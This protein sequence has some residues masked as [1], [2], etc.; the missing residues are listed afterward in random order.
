MKRYVVPAI[1]AAL[2]VGSF[3]VTNASAKSATPKAAS[4]ACPAAPDAALDAKYGVGAGALEQALACGEA[5]KLKAKGDPVIV[6][7]MNP[8]GDPAG[9]FPEYT[10]MAQAAVD[11]INTE[12]GGIGADY[13]TGTPGRPI[14]LEVCKMAINPADS[15]KCANELAAKKPLVV[16]STLNFFG[17][18][19]KILND[20][21]IPV[22]VGTPISPG[23]FT[24]PGVYAIGGG[25]GCLGVHTGLIEYLTNDVLK[26]KAN[27]KIAVPWAN[28]PPGVFCYH[29]LEKKPLNVLNGT[30]GK[31][32]SKAAGKMKGMTHIGV[33]I[34]PGS[35]D[36]T[37]DAQ[38]VLEFKPD[39]MVYSA[40]GADCWTFV[41]GLLK[42]GW[43]P[44]TPL[45]LSGAC[46]DLTTMRALGDKI[47][48][49][50][51]VGASSILD[52]DALIDPQ[53][54]R[55]AKIYGAKGKKYAK[56]KTSLEKG[57]GTQ[58]FLGIMTVWQVANE[59]G[60][61]LTGP[62]LTKYIENTTKFHTFASTGLSCKKAVAPYVAVC[63]STVSA[64]KWNGKALKQVKENF[65]GLGLIAGTDLDFGK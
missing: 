60:K 22:V 57:F 8:E 29:D 39:G 55:E 43:T 65:S 44:A 3:G 58:G 30:N 7:I 11:Y 40:Q 52:P 36:V 53:Q 34:K 10:V 54:R 51:T 27:A 1:L 25:G 6:G 2:T 56:D 59:L 5:K 32:T 4:K 37:A 17:N 45:V 35:A 38:K 12:L 63:N 24:T 9:S 33:P 49:I 21:K 46:I 61:K 42:L 15:Q 50:Y 47:K 18:H 28:T 64:S 13:A 48:G 16:Y 20:A 23:D 62:A 31:N 26:Y 19:F 41:N 14:Q